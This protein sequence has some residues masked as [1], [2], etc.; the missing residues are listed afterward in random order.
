ESGRAACTRGRRRA[1][2]PQERVDTRQD[3]Q[4]AER[5]R[6]IIVGPEP[7]AQY[8]VGLFAAGSEN[9]H[10][11]VETVIPNPAE[12][13]V[14]VQAGNHEIED[15]QRWRTL[16]DGLERLRSRGGQFDLVAFNLEVVTEPEGETRVVL[17]EQHANHATCVCVSRPA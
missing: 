11:S 15:D 16:A 2:S 17:D 3:F 13:A 12:D 10:G 4:D 6:D 5:L 14:A 7:K 9:Q 1:G 8:F